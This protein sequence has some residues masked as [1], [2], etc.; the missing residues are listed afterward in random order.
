MHDAADAAHGVHRFLRRE[1]EAAVQRAVQHLHPFLRGGA[2]FHVLHVRRGDGGRIQA[3]L[4]PD[5][6]QVGVAQ[7]LQRIAA[8]AVAGRVAQLPRQRLVAPQ[9][10]GAA[11]AAEAVEMRI[12]GWGLDPETL[13]QLL[14]GEGLQATGGAQVAGFLQHPLPVQPLLAGQA[15]AGAGLRGFPIHIRQH[16]L[17]TSADREQK[18][19]RFASFLEIP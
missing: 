15:R 3:R 5:E 19:P 1:A 17:N 10:Q 4:A 14:D 18:P 11:Q 13:G 6:V 9:R 7:G 8:R 12:D 16:A 2:Q